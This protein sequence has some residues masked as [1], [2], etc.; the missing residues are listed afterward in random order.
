MIG[1]SNHYSRYFLSGKNIFYVLSSTYYSVFYR[2]LIEAGSCVIEVSFFMVFVLAVHIAKFDM[3]KSPD[4]ILFTSML[5]IW[6]FTY[7]RYCWII[8]CVGLE[9]ILFAIDTNAAS[10]SKAFSTLDYVF[11]SIVSLI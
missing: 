1:N 10:S 8:K 9:P 11:L 7:F 6:N 3:I 5:Q 2:R 4:Q